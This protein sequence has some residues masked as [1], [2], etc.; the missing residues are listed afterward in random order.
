ML[1]E[2]AL[3]EATAPR[4]VYRKTVPWLRL[5]RRDLAPERISEV[6]G[7]PTTNPALTLLDCVT[8]LP[9]AE[10]DRLVDDALGN[11]VAPHDVADLCH[12][13]MHGSRALRQQLRDAAI[14]AASDPERRFTRALARRGLHLLANHWI[15]QYCC[16]FVDERSR[17]VVEIDGRE[18]HSEAA[19]FRK[20]RRR[21][22]AL[23]LDGWLVL[24][25]AAADIYSALDICADEAASVIR[26]R[27][28]LK[29]KR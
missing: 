22:N 8:V 7:L 24:R 3:F 6:W 4:N 9:S 26:Q 13:N 11:T 20:D 16:D 19:V 10:A 29:Q 15:G 25:Y 21:Q 27:R 17:T 23:L 12:T 18:F 28:K 5:Y 2:P 1:P 14:H